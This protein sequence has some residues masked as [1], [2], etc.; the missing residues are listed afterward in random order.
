MLFYCGG[1][2]DCHY[3]LKPPFIYTGFQHNNLEQHQKIIEATKHRF[4][5]VYAVGV[6]LFDTSNNELVSLGMPL[7]KTNIARIDAGGWMW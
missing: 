7:R 4:K 2:H 3:F 1:D 6:W 5:A